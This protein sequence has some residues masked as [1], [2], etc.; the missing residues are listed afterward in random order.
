MRKE[1]LMLQPLA[2][3]YQALDL[4]MPWWAFGRADEVIE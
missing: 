3:H 2:Y 1:T 4:T